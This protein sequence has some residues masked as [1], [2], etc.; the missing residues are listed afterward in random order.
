MSLDTSARPVAVAVEGRPGQGPG[1]LALL[2]TPRSGNNWL[3]HLLGVLY[4]MPTCAVH[5]PDEVDWDSV[6]EDWLFAVH[7]RPTR[8]FLDRLTW[9][10]FRVV[11]LIRHPLDVLISTLQFCW[12]SDSTARWLEGEGGD[13]RSLWGAM[14]R[15]AAFLQYAAGPRAAALLSVSPE[16]R[17]L[18]GSMTVGMRTS[19]PTGRGP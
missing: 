16:W 5:T 8:P 2:C 19:S 12:R 17:R 4:G 13:E 15:S 18:P 10:G 9:H 3:R 1:R 14:P 7:W 11:V 6:P